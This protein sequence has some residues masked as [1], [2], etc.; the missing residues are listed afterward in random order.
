MQVKHVQCCLK[1]IAPKL[2]RHIFLSTGTKR[3][4]IIALWSW[5]FLL[6]HKILVGNL[7][8]PTSHAST[9]NRTKLGECVQLLS[10]EFFAW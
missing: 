10:H 7:K 6:S 5:V 4:H 9:R 3:R 1:H 8:E 2:L